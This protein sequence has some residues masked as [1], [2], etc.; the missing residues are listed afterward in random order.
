MKNHDM[1]VL[2]VNKNLSLFA[3]KSPSPCIWKSSEIQ[4]GHYATLKPHLHL[5]IKWDLYPYML[6]ANE[7]SK[8][9]FVFA[10]FILNVFSSSPLRLY[11][12]SL[13]QNLLIG[14]FGW[15][16]ISTK[17][18]LK[19]HNFLSCWVRAIWHFVKKEDKLSCLVVFWKDIDVLK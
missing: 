4:F 13:E 17:L 12:F 3:W 9:A 19:K 14:N 10:C 1:V 16:Q 5:V 2:P 15:E 11:S 6:S 7:L 8:L 18:P